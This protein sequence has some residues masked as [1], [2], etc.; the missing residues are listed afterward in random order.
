MSEGVMEIQINN[1]PCK[2]IILTTRHTQARRAPRVATVHDAVKEMTKAHL[3][4]V[5]VFHVYALQMHHG[6][7]MHYPI[8][9]PLGM[10]G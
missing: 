8:I 5:H 3:T 7:P 9:Q 4:L 6:W 1:Q 2:G 10:V